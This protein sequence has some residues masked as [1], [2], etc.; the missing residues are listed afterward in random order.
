MS[1]PQKKRYILRYNWLWLIHKRK[2]FT[3]VT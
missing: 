2:D 3:T 1:K